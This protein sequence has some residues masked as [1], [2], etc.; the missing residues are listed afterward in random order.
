MDNNLL[1]LLQDFVT[2]LNKLT[3]KVQNL[4]TNIQELLIS[5][6]AF[7]QAQKH[8]PEQA[9]APEPEQAQAPEPEQ[10]QEPE[11]AQDLE[12]SMKQYIEALLLHLDM[13]NLLPEVEGIGLLDKGNSGVLIQNKVY[14]RNEMQLVGRKIA[15]DSPTTFPQ[16]VKLCDQLSSD[17]E[18]NFYL[19]LIM[20]SL[21]GI[22]KQIS[23]V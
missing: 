15:Q 20:A 9:Q 23:C 6:R 2:A 19:V 14:S 17:D 1:A 7:E 11:Q 10:T 16:L 5:F 21:Y 18:L 3:D 4:N 13:S 22:K 8:E 12:S